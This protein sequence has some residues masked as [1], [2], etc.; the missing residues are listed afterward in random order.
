MPSAP[1][2]ARLRTQRAR[3]PGS[4]AGSRRTAPRDT[5]FSPRASNEL[6]D[7]RRSRLQTCLACL[8]SCLYRS[9][10]AASD[11]TPRGSRSTIGRGMGARMF[12]QRATC[13][14]PA[15]RFSPGPRGHAR[16]HELETA[17]RHHRPRRHR[18]AG[19]S[20]A[21]A[22]R[23]ALRLRRPPTPHASIPRPPPPHHPTTTSSA[24]AIVRGQPEEAPHSVGKPTGFV[25]K[26]G[27]TRP[28]RADASHRRLRRRR[29]A[30]CSP[31]TTCA[32]PDPPIFLVC[33]RGLGLS[34]T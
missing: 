29:P 13:S 5:R 22:L 26:I 28:G 31:S 30:P 18:P 12:V 32:T 7:G 9:R 16:V 10:R 33:H 20:T 11:T 14:S 27:R 17:G 34:G 24:S 8:S 6:R 4:R 19:G 1:P 21:A 25:G 23:Q 3:R 2:P 15:R